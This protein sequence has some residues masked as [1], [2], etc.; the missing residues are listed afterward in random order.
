[1]IA[2]QNNVDT[3]SNNLSNVNT[4]GYKTETAEFKSLLYQ[5]I[6]AKTTSANG[7]NKPVSAQVGLGVR[8]SSITSHYTQGTFQ[9]P[10]EQFD[11]AI[12][13]DG[14]FRVR[15]LDGGYA[16]TRA[17]HLVMAQGDSG[18]YKLCTTEGLPVLGSNDEEIVFDESVSV[19][20]ITVDTDGNFCLP[21][22]SNNPVET[23]FKLGLYQFS[24][25]TGLEKGG[26][27]LLYETDASGIAM[28]EDE[29]TGLN[30]SSIRQMCLERSNVQVADEMVNLIVAQRAYELNSK[31]ITTSDEMLQTANNLK[32]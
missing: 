8:N 18:T 4:I 12:D 26:S 7:E 10:E 15:T 6:Q 25:P 28:S 11:F 3:I 14:F 2:Q 31:A 9:T 5:N 16:Y 21:D 32:R 17:G 27:S 22:E 20:D 23:G 13:G 19:S 29:Y 24:N 30:K 1:M